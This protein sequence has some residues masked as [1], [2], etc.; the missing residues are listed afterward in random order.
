MK[1]MVFGAWD[2]ALC[3]HPKGTYWTYLSFFSINQ[4]RNYLSAYKYITMAFYPSPVAKDCFEASAVER[5]QI[6]ELVM[7]RSDHK[8]PRTV[9]SAFMI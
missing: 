8:H 3:I 4:S 6:L 2:G 9:S 7:S 1:R 5:S